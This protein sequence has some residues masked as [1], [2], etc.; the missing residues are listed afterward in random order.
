MPKYVITS[1]LVRE[2]GLVDKFPVGSEHDVAALRRKCDKAGKRK[3]FDDLLGK[4]DVGDPVATLYF[5]R[6]YHK[7]EGAQ[8]AKESMKI[9]WAGKRKAIDVDSTL[10][11]NR[12]A[13]IVDGKFQLTKSLRRVS[14]YSE[15]VRAEI[16]RSLV[17]KPDQHEWDAENDDCWL[18][19]VESATSITKLNDTLKQI[20]RWPTD[21]KSKMDKVKQILEYAIT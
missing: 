2:I 4:V 11:Q 12:K 7:E 9:A 5:A 8:E 10:P 6:I 19:Q 20:G 3:E 21:A 13:K 15:E 14:K 1:P 16:Q 17:D 18:S